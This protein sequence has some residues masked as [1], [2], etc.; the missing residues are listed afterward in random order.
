[1]YK[2]IL[3]GLFFTIT[4]IF[5][6][7]LYILSK[8]FPINFVQIIY[9][10]NKKYL[11]F[12][13]C[14][15]FIFYTFDNLRI[16]IIAQSLGLKY[17]FLYG[18]V[19]TLV[20]TFGATVTP[21]F[22]GGE[23]LPFY[24]LKRI[25]GEIYQIMSLI[26]LKAISGFSFYLIFLP[27]TIHSL[28]RNPKEA[29]GIIFLFLFILFLTIFLF[30]L[31]Q[32]VFKKSLKFINKESFKSVKYTLSKY[33]IVCKDFF[34]EK[35][36]IF[37]L[38]LICSLFMYSSLIFTG[39]FLV[40]AFNQNTDFKKIFFAQLP[41]IYAIFMS[42][43]PG[44]SGIGEIGALTVFDKF[45]NIESLG[46]FAIFWRIITQYL[47]AF[48]GGILFLILIIKDIHKKNV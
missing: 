42:P 46:T 48:I 15:I 14:F 18:Y 35:R 12:S 38:V 23:L 2:N 10:I 28:L 1:M 27:F 47:G 44:G 40:K 24:T 4:I 7:F 26:T 11:L 29:K 45:I 20:N 22:L 37:L 36:L 43:T 3:Y 31:W 21:F 39:I 6:S 19:I 33:I 25:K 5:F 32:I 13:L 34:K 41:L 8:N 9:F 16:F 17:S 30:I